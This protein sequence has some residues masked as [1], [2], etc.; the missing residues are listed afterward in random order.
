MQHSI[1][2]S[3][4][5]ALPYLR[6]I[7][8]KNIFIFESRL[9]LWK[10]VNAFQLKHSYISNKDV[11][12]NA[13]KLWREMKNDKNKAGF[14]FCLFHGCKKDISL[15][16]EWETIIRTHKTISH[17]HKVFKKWYGAE[18]TAFIITFEYAHIWDMIIDLNC[19]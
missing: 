10:F 14:F 17:W 7:K 4:I 3:I 19:N 2:V 11:F 16:L 18:L 12:T 1:H 15:E 9:R 8:W 13:N 5:C 6:F